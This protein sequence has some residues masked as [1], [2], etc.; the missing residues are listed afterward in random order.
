MFFFS[1]SQKLC[2]DSEN[3]LGLKSG[4]L[5]PWNLLLLLLFYYSWHASHEIFIAAVVS[6]STLGTC[7]MNPCHVPHQMRHHPFHIGQLEKPHNAWK[8]NQR[9]GDIMYFVRI[10]CKSHTCTTEYFGEK[11]FVV[12][13]LFT[14]IWKNNKIAF[15]T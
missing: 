10:L 4:N 1:F 14:I 12:C 11:N 7:S 2:W 6:P 15:D 9:K 13:F 8:E 3:I 5:I